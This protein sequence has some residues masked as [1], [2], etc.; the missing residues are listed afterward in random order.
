MLPSPTQ[1]RT[2]ADAHSPYTTALFILK[3]TLKGT[4]VRTEKLDTTQKILGADT[5]PEQGGLVA[6]RDADDA[7]LVLDLTR[8][9]SLPIMTEPEMG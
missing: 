9:T 3:Y 1:R 6:L 2:R 7:D 4:V 5:D 8:R